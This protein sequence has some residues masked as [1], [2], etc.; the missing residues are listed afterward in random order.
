MDKQWPTAQERAEFR[1]RKA[2]ERE[3]RRLEREQERVARRLQRIAARGQQ[4]HPATRRSSPSQSKVMAKW[5]ITPVKIGSKGSTEMHSTGR[6]VYAGVN[7]EGLCRPDIPEPSLV[8]PR[9]DISF[10]QGTDPDLTRKFLDYQMLTP[11]QRGAYVSYLGGNRFESDDIG[12]PFLYLYGLERRLIVDARRPGEVGDREHRDV[13]GEVYKLLMAFRDQSGSF[14]MYAAS[15]LLYDGTLL[16]DMPEDTFRDA[17]MGSAMRRRFFPGADNATG[18]EY[19]LLSRMLELGYELPAEDLMNYGVRRLFL[20]SVPVEY[21]LREMLSNKAA[22]SL[23][24]RRYRKSLLAGSNSETGPGSSLVGIGRRRVPDYLPASSALQ[25]AHVTSIRSTGMPD[26]ETSGLPLKSISDLAIACMREVSEYAEIVSRPTLRG[27]DRVSVD[28]VLSLTPPQELRSHLSGKKMAMLPAAL[29]AEEM[30]GAYELEPQD[31]KRGVVTGPTQ[32]AYVALASSIGWQPILPDTIPAEIGKY[33]KIKSEDPVVAFLRGKQVVRR[34]GMQVPHRIFK[35]DGNSPRPVIGCPDSWLPVLRAFVCLC[36]VIRQARGSRLTFGECV[37]AA[38]AI[39]ADGTVIRNDAQRMAL[40]AIAS[41]FMRC[42]VS[43]VAVRDCLK[44]EG[45]MGLAQTM[46][47][48]WCQSAY[49]MMLPPDA[50]TALER[51]YQKAG[52]DKSMVLYDYHAHSSGERG[53]G[54]GDVEGF[55]IDD[56]RLRMTIE[57]TSGVQDVLGKAI[58]DDLDELEDD[59]DRGVDEESFVSGAA[60]ETEPEPPAE[61][62]GAAL[63]RAAAAYV[64]SLYVDAETDELPTADIQK[65]LMESFSLPTMAAALSMLSDVNAAHEAEHGEPLVD[66]DGPDAYLNEG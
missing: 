62:D 43:P 48:D 40:F 19:M 15:L 58:G 39:G 51:L 63:V 24:S 27:I 49:G 64:K 22:M 33:L 16:R 25:K 8:N 54:L 60:G 52:R 7:P 59:V 29:M 31:T 35:E 65:A 46:V 61:Q 6:F 57:E 11:E 5:R 44:E 42:S 4:R 2:E 34:T 18:Y 23:F 28:T 66:V 47:F 3:M 13:A 41:A 14:A 56:D 50:M 53:V 12:Y 30:K 20:G 10:D 9:Y 38:K 32:A 17:F 21:D 55:E 37:S 36:D 26:L 45:T 1:K